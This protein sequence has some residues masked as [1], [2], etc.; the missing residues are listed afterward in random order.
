[1]VYQRFLPQFSKKYPG[2]N[3][4]L[5][6]KLEKDL[7]EELDEGKVDFVVANGPVNNKRYIEQKICNEEMILCVPKH[8]DLICNDNKLDLN[9][10]SG[11]P[12]IVLNNNQFIQSQVNRL[13]KDNNILQ[14]KT[15]ECRNIITQIAMVEEGIGYAI[16]PSIVDCRFLESKNICFYRIKQL[17]PIR[18]IYIYYL[19]D[20]YLNNAS[21]YL[22]SL[23][24]NM[25]GTK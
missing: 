5:E 10:L 17:T 13:F 7:F 12:M 3:L 14:Q 8:N 1:M 11:K 20:H 19:K 16:V 23:I 4:I 9:S 15:I 24:S 2:I 25:E 6:E 22:V 18:E 21:K